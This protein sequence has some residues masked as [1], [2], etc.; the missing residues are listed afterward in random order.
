MTK[1][2]LN[3]VTPAAISIAILGFLVYPVVLAQNESVEYAQNVLTYA[4][5]AMGLL[6]VLK[7]FFYLLLFIQFAHDKH[8]TVHHSLILKD[9]G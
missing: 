9:I 8:T 6:L 5:V 1:V 4:L 3:F 7:A 2:L